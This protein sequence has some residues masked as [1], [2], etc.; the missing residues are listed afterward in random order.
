[1]QLQLFIPQALLA[2]VCH[3]GHESAL[4]HLMARARLEPLDDSI[5][6]LICQQAGLPAG[7]QGAGSLPI[8]AIS[9][10]GEGGQEPAVAVD[11]G[12]FLFA[13]PVHFVLQRDSFSLSDPV[14]MALS[15]EESSSLLDS[16]NRHFAAD[17]LRFMAGSSGHW[18][19][20][21]AEQPNIVSCHPGLAVDRDINAF[22]PKGNG[23]ARWNQL[24]N[25]IQMLLHSH[26]VNQ[27][28]ESKG[29]VP[30]NSL[31]FWGEGKLPVKGKG[32]PIFAHASTPLM[33]GLGKLGKIECQ[34]IPAAFPAA[35]SSGIQ[36]VTWVQLDESTDIN[37]SWFQAC[38]RLLKRGDVDSL[39]L[40]FAVN[41]KILQATLRRRDL[42]KFWRGSSAIK[43]YFEK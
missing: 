4:A 16:L 34:D 33:R 18:Y 30:C 32:E 42:W 35:C 20:H 12:Y 8:A 29:L 40:N 15:P 21:L 31:W 24:I 23:A 13:D 25:E 26:P 39:Q 17:G 14:P 38:A 36:A 22:L 43:T 1:M 27:A 6:S 10:L 11:E 37:D 3:L 28:R 41:G 9:H 19:L 2:Q 5:E 7:A